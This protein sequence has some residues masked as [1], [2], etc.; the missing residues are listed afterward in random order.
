MAHNTLFLARKKLNFWRMQNSVVNL[1][2][3][4]QNIL[5]VI[6]PLFYSQLF[7]SF[8]PL[9]I[10]KYVVKTGDVAFHVC[11]R[12]FNAVADACLRCEVYNH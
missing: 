1:N 9:E 5:Y 10:P 11:I 12:V 6:V 4:K 7:R 3:K 2:H 8:P